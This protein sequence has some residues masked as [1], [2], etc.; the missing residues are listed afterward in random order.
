MKRKKITNVLLG[1]V[2]VSNILPGVTLAQ[3]NLPV[4]P[5]S[6]P[7]S[8]AVAK[9]EAPFQFGTQIRVAQL[10]ALMILKHPYASIQ[11]M[12]GMMN[13]YNKFRNSAQNWLDGIQSQIINVNTNMKAFKNVT[14]SYYDTLSNL[15]THIN[16]NVQ[17]KENFKKGINAIQA[18]LTQKQNETR[19]T[20]ANIENFK[21]KVQ[22][23]TSSFS[24]DV[25]N[26]VNK[27][28]NAD[29]STRETMLGVQDRL[30]EKRDQVVLI[31]EKYNSQQAWLL[32]SGDLVPAGWTGLYTMA[33]HLLEVMKNMK[34][35]RTLLP[36]IESL[37]NR[38]HDLEVQL[39][40]TGTQTT[41]LSVLEKVLTTFE[42]SISNAKTV[43]EDIDNSWS[44]LN[45][46]LNDLKSM[47]ENNNINQQALQA[48]LND[49]KN[50][51]DTLAR[52]SEE[53]GKVLSN[54]NVSE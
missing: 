54:M 2:L 45:Q 14:T 25:Q 37:V 7:I 29:K 53:Q 50:T 35:L 32:F 47:V 44:E 6:I 26:F 41:K 20:I 13:H 24:V 4:K 46:Q 21:G 43:V 48:K 16:E 1:T 51:V 12:P 38:Y 34:E 49:F 23:D 30:K 36:A 33:Q 28:S 9:Q 22:T 3:E 11:D 5:S 27:L 18:R 52:T 17:N 40:H 19:T 8:A 42:D 15:V 10:D 31:M 39:T